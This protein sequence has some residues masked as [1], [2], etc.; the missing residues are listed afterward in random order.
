MSDPYEY[1]PG[2]SLKLKRSRDDS[3]KGSKKK[4]KSSKPKLDTDRV[5]EEAFMESAQG[6][7]D[8]SDAVAGRSSSAG[9]S[10]RNSPA[11]EGGG[12]D[13]EAKR[14]EAEKKFE[15][16]QRRRREEKIRK[17]ASMTHKDRVHEFNQKLEAL[18]EHHDIPKVG[19]G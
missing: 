3:E 8:K 17:L 1:R 16:S 2:G 4:K 18:S 12:K 11:V 13:S 5:K 15:E 9:A 6:S 7:A 19:P 14:T 10:G